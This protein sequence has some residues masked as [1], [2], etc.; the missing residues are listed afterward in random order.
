MLVQQFKIDDRERQFRLTINRITD[1]DRAAL[2][3]L[4]R[5]LEPHM[6]KIVD[7]FYGHLAKFPEALAVIQ[8][9]GSSVDR[10]K[11]TNPE[12][13]AAIFKAEFDLGYFEGRLRIGKI[14]AQI[15]L[16]P[17]WF[18]AAMSSYYDM[19]I[20]IIQK[21]YGFNKGKATRALV[22]L[23]KALNI[24]QELIIEAYIEFGF[25]GEIRTIVEES[26]D[27]A[28]ALRA[29]SNNLRDSSEEAGRSTQELSN[30][31]EQLAEAS[32]RQ[33]ESTMR[34]ASSMNALSESGKM[35]QSAA[36]SQTE[37]LGK[38]DQAV[39][40]VQ[41]KIEEIDTQA[42]VWE[43]IRERIAAMEKVQETV[44]T[45]AASVQQMNARSDEIGRIV[46]TIDD[47]AAQTNLLALN[48]AIEAARAGE[49]GRG[50]AVVAEEVR[51]LA[52][53]S[54]AATKEISNLILA[55]Q[56]GSQE[57]VQSIEQTIA[58][59]A[60]ASEVTAQA[61]EVLAKIAAIA[62][63]TSTVNKDLTV[64]MKQVNEVTEQS[65]TQLDEMSNEIDSVNELIESI[66][67]VTEE[68]SAASQEV[69]ASTQQMTAQVQELVASVQEVDQQ[70]ETLA[71]VVRQARSAIEKGQDDTPKLRAA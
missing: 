42:S 71:R 70:V 40:S 47:I 1:Q 13:F 15:G 36:T 44:G 46:Q 61:A 12:F 69:S 14:H 32:Q 35:L 51:K 37:A 48:A 10:L 68:N 6:G 34:A 45:A 39:K 18:Y 21:G 57:A 38:A 27:V 52:E 41:A 53:N 31:C 24:D 5:V 29:S 26:T 59:F 67:A 43:S 50:F 30:V 11:K 20:P 60:G 58:D 63:E 23:Q 17:K 22:A 4:K 33:A 8:S 2:R 28:G 56:H 65:L 55:V 49:H 25:I 64:A 16:E 7:E 9:A 66:A 62:G 19:L 54:S 3:D